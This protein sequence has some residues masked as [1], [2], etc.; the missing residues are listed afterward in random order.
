M[1]IKAAMWVHGHNVLPEYVDRLDNIPGAG[2][3]GLR[4]GWGVTFRGQGHSFNWFHFSMPTPVIL[5]DTRPPLKKIFVFYKTNHSKVTAIHLW[6]GIRKIHEIGNLNLQG[7][8]TIGTDA[9]NNWIINPPLTIV[10]GLG[11]S[12]GVQFS[13]FIDTPEPG[14]FFEIMF[15]SAGADYGN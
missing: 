7:D 10:Y 15:S 14:I 11:I 9:S 4:K 12:I 6:D 13:G 3:N 2:V 5:D 1:A 8:H